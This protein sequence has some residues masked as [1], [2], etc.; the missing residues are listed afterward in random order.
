[1]TVNLTNFLLTERE[2]KGKDMNYYVSNNGSD[3]GMGTKEQPFRTISKAAKVAMPGDVVNVAGGTYREWVKPEVGGA[4]D[5]KRITYQAIEGEKVIIKGSEVIGNW[6]LVE[7]TLW[8]T[9]ISN[10]IFGD[11]NPYIQ[12]IDGDWMVSPQGWRVHAGDVYL[13]GKSFYEGMRTTTHTLQAAELVQ[14]S[15]NSHLQQSEYHEYFPY[16]L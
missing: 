6:E 14:M 16:Y 3:Y 11:Y 4:S 10:D 9:V 12:T 2:R 13:N 15:I 5:I 8:K 1:M 7:G